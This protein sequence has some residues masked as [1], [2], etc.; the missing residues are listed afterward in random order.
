[1]SFSFTTAADERFSDVQGDGFRW[2]GGQRDHD[3]FR[4]GTTITVQVLT[5]NGFDF[6][7]DDPISQ[8]GAGTVVLG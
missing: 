7:S 6:E 5:P 4:N 3:D 2:N 1:M 8:M